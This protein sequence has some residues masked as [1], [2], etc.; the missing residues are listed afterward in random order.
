MDR[1]PSDLEWTVSSGCEGER[2]LTPALIQHFL[3]GALR[4]PFHI[5]KNLKHWRV[6]HSL[7]DSA[8]GA[9]NRVSAL[10]KVSKTF[11]FEVPPLSGTL[12]S[13]KSLQ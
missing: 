6:I 3:L 5:D 9:Y 12:S 2:H 7:T 4:S 1:D 10:P 11:E 13:L 8:G